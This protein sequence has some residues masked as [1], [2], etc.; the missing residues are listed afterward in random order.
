M[1]LPLPTTNAAA[2]KRL[3][4]LSKKEYNALKRTTYMFGSQLLAED[5][6]GSDTVDPVSE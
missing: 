2:A 5:A 3:D 6:D 1:A 4:K